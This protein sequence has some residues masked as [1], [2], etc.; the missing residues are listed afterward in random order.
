VGV[1]SASPAILAE[2]ELRE[3][4][5]LEEER[6]AEAQEPG[7]AG[8][9]GAGEEPPLFLPATPNFMASADPRVQGMR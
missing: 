9:L 5:E 6:R 3:W 4:R 2:W 7:D 8:E 1:S